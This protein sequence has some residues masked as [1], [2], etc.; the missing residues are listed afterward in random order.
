MNH[1]AQLIQALSGLALTVA[2]YA[3]AWRRGRAQ[4]QREGRLA[5]WNEHA[6]AVHEE[7]QRRRTVAMSPRVPRRSS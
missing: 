3:I 6:A 5:G 7:A 2:T 1:L 4:G